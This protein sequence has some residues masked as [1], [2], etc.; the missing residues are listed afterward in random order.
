MGHWHGNQLL[1]HDVFAIV[2]ETLFTNW[3]YYI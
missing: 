1:T 3:T 2:Q